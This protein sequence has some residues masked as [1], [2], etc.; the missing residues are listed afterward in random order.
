M[1]KKIL[2]ISLL[3]TSIFISCKKGETEKKKED[4]IIKNSQNK[5]LQVKN[6]KNG[7]A[8][9]PPVGTKAFC[10]VMENEFKTTANTSFSTHKGKHYAFCCGGCKPKFDKNPEKFIK[11]LS[12]KPIVKNLKPTFKGYTKKPKVGSKAFCPVM[13]KKFTVS[14]NS[15]MSEYKGKHVAFCCPGCKPKFDKNPGKYLNLDKI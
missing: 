13:N 8:K 4:K 3:S 5:T 14:K 6:V 2:I 7:F 11:K 1:L 15:V 9:K 10:P 12:A